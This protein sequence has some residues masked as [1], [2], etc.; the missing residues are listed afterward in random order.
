MIARRANPRL[1]AFALCSG[2]LME[3]SFFFLTEEKHMSIDRN[4]SAVNFGTMQ[5][6]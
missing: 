3:P 5:Y 6:K 2:L 1:P 4:F